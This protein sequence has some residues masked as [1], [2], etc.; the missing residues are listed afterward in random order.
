[1]PRST[2]N[3]IWAVVLV[4]LG[5]LGLAAAVFGPR[6]D[7]GQPVLGPPPERVEQN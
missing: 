2:S 4:I 6:L 1:M 5:L 7:D 3:V